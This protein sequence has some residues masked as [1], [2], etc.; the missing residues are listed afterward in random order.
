MPEASNSH[1]YLLDPATGDR[2]YLPRKV[3]D[4]ATLLSRVGFG[5]MT[6]IFNN[7]EVGSVPMQIDAK[8]CSL[9]PSELRSSSSS[10]GRIPQLLSTLAEKS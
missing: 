5:Q 7:G 1:V 6:L 4:A 2:I 10:N 9:V 3:W 8:H